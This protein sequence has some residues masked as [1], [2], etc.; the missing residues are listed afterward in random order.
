MARHH[1]DGKAMDVLAENIEGR[2]SAVVGR[3]IGVTP[4][5]VGSRETKRSRNMTMFI[6]S[7][8]LPLS[9]G[10]VESYAA[11]PPDNHV[12]SDRLVMA[13]FKPNDDDW[14]QTLVAGSIQRLG[15]DADVT[16]SGLP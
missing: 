16:Q 12:V 9:K 1:I 14:H 7:D 13:V 10:F 4:S 5:A 15:R 2:S 6:E 3:Y 11:F 8:A